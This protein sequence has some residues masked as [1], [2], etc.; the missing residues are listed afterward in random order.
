VDVHVSDVI[1]DVMKDFS[2]CATNEVDTVPFDTCSLV[3][4]RRSMLWV[5]ARFRGQS[6]KP[7]L[8]HSGIPGPAPG[9]L[10]CPVVLVTLVQVLIPS[11]P[12]ALLTLVSNY[13]QVNNTAY[14]L[15]RQ[16]IDRLVT[17]TVLG[18]HCL[19]LGLVK[20]LRS[21]YMKL[22]EGIMSWTSPHYIG[23]HKVYVRPT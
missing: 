17:T 22:V 7:R 14:S 20:V 11:H 4:S 9:V 8:N 15:E 18:S 1:K 23:L 13:D 19:V 3:R 2:N 6:R 10:S 21:S 12:S 5:P 16:Q